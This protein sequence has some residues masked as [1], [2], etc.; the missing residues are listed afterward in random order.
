LDQDTFD[1]LKPA[2]TAFGRLGAVL[3]VA[4]DVL[5]GAAEAPLPGQPG[6][7]RVAGHDHDPFRILHRR[8]GRR[9]GKPWLPVTEELSVRV[10]LLADGGP[11]L[12]Q[13]FMAEL[14]VEHLGVP[15]DPPPHGRT[16]RERLHEAYL[17]LVR[18][19]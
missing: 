3:P 13:R 8:A 17:A 19:T 1:E 9:L 15:A 6:R 11:A 14:R 16:V 10:R 4:V 2:R 5:E 12:W 18:E 7:Q